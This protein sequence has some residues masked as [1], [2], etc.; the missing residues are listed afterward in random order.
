M[1]VSTFLLAWVM[2]HG[3]PVASFET[4]AEAEAEA[5]VLQRQNPD[6]RVRAE[7]DVEHV[8]EPDTTVEAR[9]PAD[10]IGEREDR[11]E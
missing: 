11:Q 5:A 6:L 2:V 3:F 1:G 10:R 8:S 4:C 9:P 7:C